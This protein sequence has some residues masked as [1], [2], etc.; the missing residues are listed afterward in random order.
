MCDQRRGKCFRCGQAGHI[1]RDCPQGG[2]L[3]AQ[4]VASAPAIPA[5]YAMPPAA[6]SAGRAAAP[7]QP[8]PARS[9]PIGRMYA[10]QVQE[11]ELIEA[12]E[13]NV[14]AG[15]V[16]VNGVRA[17]ALF[18]TGAS[19]SFI[20]RSFA[21]VHDIEISLGENVWRVEGPGRA[22]LVRKRCLA[23]PVQVGDWIMPVD[24]LVLKRLKEFD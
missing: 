9:A 8:E 21:Q 7:R 18:D 4:S 6:A 15:M 14:V 5:R 16:L 12:E 11:E 22:F 20:N 1:A 10:A 3:P 13:R 2:A 17:R 24:L 23:C 19:H